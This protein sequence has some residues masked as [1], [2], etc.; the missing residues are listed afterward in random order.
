MDNSTIICFILIILV[1][2]SI[3]YVL[4]NKDKTIKNLIE[5]ITIAGCVYCVIVLMFTLAFIFNPNIHSLFPTAQY[6]LDFYK[7]YQSQLIISAGI[8]AII[9]AIYYSKR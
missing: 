1:L 9:D 5:L 2:I 6:I 8:I 4:N 7:K 3:I